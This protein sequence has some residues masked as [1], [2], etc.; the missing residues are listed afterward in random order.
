MPTKKP[1]SEMP[2]KLPY[3]ILN[4][5]DDNLEVLIY[6]VIGETWDGDGT[7]A[8]RFAKDLRAAGK[9]KTITV[10]INSP[11][12]AVWDSV[13][14]YN[15][16]KQ[17]K[18]RVEVSIDGLAAS[19][20]SVIAMA[21]DRVTMQPGALMMIHNPYGMAWGESK[22]MRKYADMLDKARDS[23]VV[24]YV[25]K[26]GLTED[27]VIT[28]L[29]E[30]TWMDADE[31]VTSGFADE[32]SEDSVALAAHYSMDDLPNNVPRQ[33]QKRVQAIVAISKED[34]EMT[35]TPPENTDNK[36]TIEQLESLKG[37]DAAFVLAQIKAGATY[38]Q[39]VVA[40]NEKLFDELQAASAA[41]DEANANAVEVS[42]KLAA[43]SA[44]A[45]AEKSRHQGVD[46]VTSSKPASEGGG[47]SV[48]VWGDDPVGFYR[49]ELAKA[50]AETGDNMKAV[51]IMKE[52]FPG[53]SDAIAD[54]ATNHAA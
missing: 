30:E 35:K 5:A 48:A 28:L 3:Q 16:L 33:W 42:Q 9:P 15:T 44:S 24:A 52:K 4:A 8:K 47:K 34:D 36:A 20:A 10:R 26:T 25:E 45:A 39:S 40:L 14:I 31:A 50:A 41:R 27:E 54:A 12:G 46:P 19:G 38:E 7:T 1:I 13:A 49:R 2:E 51:R 18:A 43:A 37:A 11:G 6:D 17:H 21:G 32:I 29:D 53:L 22:D 23:I